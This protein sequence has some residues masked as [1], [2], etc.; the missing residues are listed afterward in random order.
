VVVLR[1]GEIVEKGPTQKV[2]SQPS[3]EY[4]KALVEAFQ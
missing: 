2:I 1:Q 4:T 3:H